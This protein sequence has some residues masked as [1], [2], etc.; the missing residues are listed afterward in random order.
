MNQILSPQ[1]Q[2]I[3]MRWALSN[4]L[5]AFDFDGTLAPIVADPQE[6]KLPIPTWQALDA[7]ARI[8]PVAI[9]SG[10]S[11]ASLQARLP[12]SVRLQVGNHGN[13]GLPGDSL[14][15]A[16][17]IRVCALWQRQIEESVARTPALQG[18][19]LE[20]KGSTLAVHYRHC[21]RP[22]EAHE[23]LQKLLSDL[24][25]APRLLGGVMVFNVL[26][27]GSLTKL[28][29]LQRLEAYSQ[30]DHLLFVGDDITDEVAFAHAPASW[31]TIRVGLHARTQA[32]YRVRHPGDVCTLLQQ[33]TQISQQ[34][35][36][37][38]ASLHRRPVIARAIPPRDELFD[39]QT[40]EP[41]REVRLDEEDEVLPDSAP[42]IPPIGGIPTAY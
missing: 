33:L 34:A 41:L 14:A 19:L 9:V 22:K 25:P 17:R 36:R 15:A 1:N 20:N 4:T 42:K 3:L 28:E 40:W 18:I 38:Q 12:D 31:L 29:A 35:H 26:P 16:G 23:L 11:C 27:Q 39:P 30:C 32:R 6:A 24:Q 21:A 7:L 2:P 10:R 13:E 5:M 8:T 37:R